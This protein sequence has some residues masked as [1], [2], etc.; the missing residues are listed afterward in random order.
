MK[1]GDRN[2]VH[3]CSMIVP[4]GET[5]SIE[6]LLGSWTVRIRINFIQSGDDEKSTI[7]VTAASG[8]DGES[9]ITFV[10]WRNPIGTATTI[11][12]V[13]ARTN[14]NQELLI[15]AA[16]WMIGNVNKVDIHFL[17]GTTP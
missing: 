13:I 9:L 14:T 16:H 3:N 6:F 10:N 15:M 4:D 2:V 11:P 17:L 12:V 7:T 5:A 1:I 8:V